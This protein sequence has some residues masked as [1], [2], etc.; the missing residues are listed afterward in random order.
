MW[1]YLAKV[2]AP[3]PKKIKI[4]SKTVDCVFIGYAQ[5]SSAYRFLVYKSK[6]SHYSQEYNYRIKKC[7]IFEHIFPFI[8][9]EH[10]LS[11]S[12]QVHEYIGS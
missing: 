4:G 7:F 6:K 8:N 10:K 9:K 5:N 1:G 12:N 3:T 2:M 11:S